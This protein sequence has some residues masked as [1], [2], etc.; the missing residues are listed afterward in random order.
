[1]PKPYSPAPQKRFV[2]SP[3]NLKI[4][5]KDWAANGHFSIPHPA[6]RAAAGG[7]FLVPMR[8]S[9]VNEPDWPARSN[10]WLGRYAR[11]RR[12]AS[13]GGEQ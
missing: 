13:V 1:M 3:A 4:A 6:L 9:I 12:I 7:F 8:R 11:F 10:R 2:F 5:P